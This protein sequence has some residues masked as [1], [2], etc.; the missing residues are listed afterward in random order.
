MSLRARQQ[1]GCE[2]QSHA[3]TGRP[4][5]EA[6]SRPRLELLSLEKAQEP[7][8][9]FNPTWE[10]VAQEQEKKELTL[11]KQEKLKPVIREVGEKQGKGTGPHCGKSCQLLIEPGLDSIPEFSSVVCSVQSG[12]I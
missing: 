3:P 10:T 11:R 9:P 5:L 12:S 7:A 1:S 4:P 6:R 2:N 8:E